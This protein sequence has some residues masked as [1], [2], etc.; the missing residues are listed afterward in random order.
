VVQQVLVDQ[1]VLHLP[2]NLSVHCFQ[3]HQQV[4]EDPVDQA[5]QIDPGVLSG[6]Q[7]PRLQ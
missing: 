3:Y 7:V 5:D 1:L 2:V 6:Q 4:P